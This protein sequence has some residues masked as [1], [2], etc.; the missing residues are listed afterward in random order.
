MREPRR[1]EPLRR[2]PRP[3]VRQRRRRE[4]RPPVRQRRRREPRRRVRQVRRASAAGAGVSAGGAAAGAAGGAVATAPAAGAGAAAA[5]AAPATARTGAWTSTGTPVTL[6]GRRVSLPGWI[7]GARTVR[8][9]PSSFWNRGANRMY[10]KTMAA[11][12]TRP[13]RPSSAA[14][15]YTQPPVLSVGVALGGPT[16]TWPSTG[17]ILARDPCANARD[18]CDPQMEPERGF[19]PLTYHLRGG[20]SARLS[21]SGQGSR[22]TAGN[23]IRH[24][25]P[26]GR[27]LSGRSG[28]RRRAK[29]A[30]TCTRF[31]RDPVTRSVWFRRLEGSS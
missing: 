22:E 13:R 6:T 16:M 5:A 29:V 9:A 27:S 3:P 12:I 17:R 15:P 11:A 24:L 10:P 21:Y 23:Q 30:Q 4:P 20:C 26:L 31:P 7:L 14:V 28:H 19:E 2:E 25:Y 8:C 18:R 1:R